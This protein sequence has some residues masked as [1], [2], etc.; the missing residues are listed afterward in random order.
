MI[1]ST[2]L[3]LP[4]VLAWICM[5]AIAAPVVAVAAD[6]DVIELQ[7]QVAGLSEQVRN[8]QATI[9]L[10][11]SSVDQ[12]LGAQGS[13]LQQ[14]LDGVSRIH[15]ESA[16]TGKNT[17][18]QLAQQEQKVAV[19]VANL[20]AKID[21]MLAAFSGAQESI[22]DM[23]SRLGKLEQQIVDLANVVKAL[24]TNPGPPPN[25]QT[26]GGPPPGV[27]AVG[28]LQDAN[29]DQLSGKDDLA[30]QGYSDYLKYFG[31]T[32]KAAD[33]Q[34]HI[35]EIMLRQGNADH[36]IQ[37]FDAVIAQFPKSGIAPDA[38]YKKA[39]ALKKQGQRAEATK[40][41]R[42]LVRLYPDSDDA[43][44]ARADLTAPPR[45]PKK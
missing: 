36:A 2:G 9:G 35:G 44:K 3:R 39:E 34:F 43:A 14:A 31:D 27:T 24:Q 22:G 20:N 26:A 19:P 13:Q 1:N 23:N 45:S 4:S 38:L 8:L 15:T 42:D 25:T 16:L 12:K 32:Q 28:L 30:L 7:R 11:Q 33:A 29:R 40:T 17:A 37:A 5:S 10:L 18:D 21:Q 6:K 41:L